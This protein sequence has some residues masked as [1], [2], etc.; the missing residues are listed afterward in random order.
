MSK[1]WG[2]IPEK[3]HCSESFIGSK[4]VESIFNGTA[5]REARMGANDKHVACGDKSQTLV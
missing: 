4:Q 5:V 3:V 2:F 1:R